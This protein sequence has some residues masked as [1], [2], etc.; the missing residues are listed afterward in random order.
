M[1]IWKRSIIVA[2]IV[3]ALCAPTFAMAS[4]ANSFGDMSF[5]GAQLTEFKARPHHPG[6]PPPKKKPKPP[7]KVKKPK[8]KPHKPGRPMP[9]PPPPRHHR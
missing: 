9:P 1:R 3:G 7:K 8:P 4:Q 5:T 6:P 2:A